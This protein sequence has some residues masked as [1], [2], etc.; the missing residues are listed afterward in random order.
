MKEKI[1]IAMMAIMITLSPAYAQLGSQAFPTASH[2]NVA[3]EANIELAQTVFSDPG[4]LPDHPLYFMKRIGEKM[5]LFF[6][7][8][9]AEKAKLHLDFAKTRLAEAKTLVNE[10]KTE[11]AKQAIDDFDKEISMINATQGIGNNVSVIAKSEDILGKS[12]LVLGL[13]LEKAPEEAKP[14]IENALNNSL[15]KHA[16][17][18]NETRNASEI[19]NRIMNEIRNNA[20]WKENMNRKLERERHDEKKN[21]NPENAET[22]DSIGVMSAGIVTGVYETGQSGNENP[23]RTDTGDKPKPIIQPV[24]PPQIPSVEKPND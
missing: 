3:T 22:N 2:S 10:N 19:K 15:K 8:N 12:A 1:I 7:F 23:K 17:M 6:T 14:A 20:N 21:S 16:E 24:E 5:R 9:Q 13:V 18:G 11:K 4:I